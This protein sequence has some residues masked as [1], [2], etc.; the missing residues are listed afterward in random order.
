MLSYRLISTEEVRA[1]MPIFNTAMA[2]SNKKQR[3]TFVNQIRS[4]LS[5]VAASWSGAPSIKSKLRHR[6][7]AVVLLDNGTMYFA[8]MDLFDKPAPLPTLTPTDLRE[9]L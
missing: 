7:V 1:L 8:E 5:M 6:G 2:S 3:R 9:N 4:V